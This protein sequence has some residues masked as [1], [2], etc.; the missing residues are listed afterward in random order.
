MKSNKKIEQELKSQILDKKENETKS[1]LLSQCDLIASEFMTC[2]NKD[3][4][5]HI[6]KDEDVYRY[7]R[8]MYCDG[9]NESNWFDLTTWPGYL[10]TSGGHGTYV[11]S[12]EQDMFNFFRIGRSVLNF[13]ERN[14]LDILPGYWREKLK[15]NGIN[16]GQLESTDSLYSDEYIG[17]LYAIVWG[18]R[19]YDQ[20]K[21]VSKNK[22][23]IS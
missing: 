13:I 5:I 22:E 15:C 2:V 16:T 7:V 1:A 11:F 23:K 8:F 18:I 4:K 17:C 3:H 9:R 19:K 10:C 21:N 20:A 12:Y 6:E 14:S